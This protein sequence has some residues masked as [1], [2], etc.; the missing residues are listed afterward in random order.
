MV[1]LGIRKI[2]NQAYRRLSTVLN[3]GGT[4]HAGLVDTSSV[5]LTHS[6]VPI[7]QADLT[8]YYTWGLRFTTPAGADVRDVLLRPYVTDDWDRIFRGESAD[9]PAPNP[10]THDIVITHLGLSVSNA[11]NFSSAQF[12]YLAGFTTAGASQELAITGFLDDAG[13]QGMVQTSG[14]VPY[15]LH[16]MPLWQSRPRSP[17]LSCRITNSDANQVDVIAVG[18]V[19]PKGVLDRGGVY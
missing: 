16:P 3:L 18:M 8:D 6:M 11:A 13:V 19:A 12:S 7:V 5:F 2:G 4:K 17:S 14:G 9:V 10:F 15:Y 1:D